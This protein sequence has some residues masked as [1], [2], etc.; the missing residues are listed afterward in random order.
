MKIERK[1]YE[2]ACSFIHYWL[3][4][5]FLFSSD[6]NVVVNFASFRSVHETVLEILKFNE[7]IKTIAII[8]EGKHL[9]LY[10]FHTAGLVLN[11][12]HHIHIEKQ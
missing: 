10:K 7:Q 12:D 6:S 2:V 8:A 3:G 9:P 1:K 4:F 11:H 5:V